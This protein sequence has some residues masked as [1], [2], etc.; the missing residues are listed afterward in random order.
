MNQTRPTLVQ[1]VHNQLSDRI[2]SG[3][4]AGP[5]SRLPSEHELSEEFGVSRTP[6]RP[7]ST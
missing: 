7:C 2:T 6:I 4:Y 5:G 1:Q 3:Q